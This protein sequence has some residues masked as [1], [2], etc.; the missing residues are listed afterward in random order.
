MFEEL[1]LNNQV[2]PTVPSPLHFVPGTFL[3]IF[4]QI[5]AAQYF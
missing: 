3:F 5:F 1:I 4:L 2:F